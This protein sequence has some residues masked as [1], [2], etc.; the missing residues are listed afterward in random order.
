[1][2]KYLMTALLLSLTGN[3]FAQNN[4]DFAQFRNETG[5]FLKQ[6][7]K[8][9]GRDWLTLGLAGAG[10]FETHQYDRE[11]RNSALKHSGN[12]D[13]FPVKVGGQWGGFF[14]TPML[15]AGLL[16]YSWAS[17]NGAT[18]KLGFEILQAAVYAETVSV[19][20]KVIIGRARPGVAGTNSRTYRAFSSKSSYNS[21]PG[22]HVNA[23][24]SLST[25]LS[26]STD[27]IFLKSLAYLPAGLTTAERIYTDAHW[28]SDCFFGAAIG[29]FSAVWVMDLHEK[30]AAGGSLSGMKLHPYLSGDA[31]G[32]GLTLS[33]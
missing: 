6:P 22:G 17:E 1:M 2:K 20:L 23:A 18:K 25:V 16:T 27:S 29:Y 33:M 10:T 4:Y 19:A 9:E 26:R 32:L 14:I 5:L 24:F 15:G 12:K 11:I 30:K 7:G 13:T 3:L 21:F 31:L 28:A 8:W